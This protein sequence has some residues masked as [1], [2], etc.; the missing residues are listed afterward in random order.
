MQSPRSATPAHP[1]RAPRQRTRSRRQPQTP[2]CPAEAALAKARAQSWSGQHAPA[3]A[4][5]TQALEEQPAPAL[6]MDLLDLRAEAFIASGRFPDAAADADT[7]VALAKAQK[8]PVLGIQALN[9]RAVVLMR[10]GDARTAVQ[11]ATRAVALAT[12]RQVPQLLPHALL[13]LA[14]ALLRVDRLEPS[15]ARARRA[16][17][18]FEASRDF[19]QLG[20][21]HWVIAFAH[22]NMS[23]DAQSQVAAQRALAL[24][25]QTGDAMGAGNALNVL[26]FSSQDIAERMTLLS[27]TD[28]AFESA[29]YEPG[30]AMVK[31]NLAIACAELGLYRRAGRLGDEV[32]TLITN[33]GGQ[34][35]RALQLSGLLAWKLQMGDVDSVHA[36]WQEYEDMIKSQDSATLGVMWVRLASTLAL[37]DGDSAKSVRLLRTWLR[38]DAA[39]LSGFELQVLVPLVDALLV[40]GNLRAALHTSR[41]AAKL[42]EAQNFARAQYGQS[43]DIWWAHTRA[44]LA[45]GLDEQA[46]DALQRAYGLLLDAVRNLHDE[47]L[48]RS[49]LNKVEVNRAIVR[50]WLRESTLR[51]LPRAQRFAHLYIESN[52]GEPFQRLVD[53]GTRMNE[54]RSSDEL[55][56]FLIDEVTELSG[57]ERVLLVIEDDGAFEIGGALLPAGENAPAL[58][59]AIDP[60]LLEA[61]TT[62]AVRLRHGPEGV[63]RIKQRSCLVAPLVAQTKLLGYLYVDIDGAF[64]RFHEADSDLVAMLASQGAVALANAR[65]ARALERKVALR[66]SELSEALERQT[67]TAEVLKVLGSSLTDTQPVFDAIV[68]H[69]GHLLHGS[70][71]VLWLVEPEGLRARASN[72][73]MPSK[74]VPLDHSSPIGACVVEQ[75]VIHIPDLVAA[76]PQH[77]LLSELGAGS[78]FRSGLYTPLISDG[79]AI[80]GL[81]VLQKEAQAFDEKDQRLLGAFVDQAVIAIQNANMFR[82]TKEALERQTAM[83]EVLQ[84]IASSMEDPQP[85]FDKILESCQC[86]FGADQVGISLAG[87]DGMV[88]L[89]A[90]RGS[91]RE[92]LERIYPRPMQ[93]SPVAMAQKVH[94]VVHIP[95]V[96]ANDAL[97]PF[98]HQ[99][100]RHTGNYG[101]MLAPLLWEDH[102]IGSIHVSRQPPGPFPDRDLSLLR[103][104]GDQAVIAIQN[105]KLFNEAQEARA[106]A[107][108]ANEAKSAFLATMSHEIRTP[109]NAVIG[110]S[111]LL[112]DTA[113]DHDQREFATTIRDS[114]D[115]LLAIIN[116][117][118]DF[119]KIEAGRM[120][121]ELRPFD[122]RECVE[123][124]LELVSPRATE[125]R[126]DVA[127]LFEGDVP[128]VI[129]GDVTRLRQILLN[130]LSNAVKFTEAGE[131]VVTVHADPGADGT[132]TLRFAVRDTGIGLSKK[133]M[134]RLFQSFTQADSSTTRKYG[135]TGLGLA[136]SKRLAELMGGTMQAESR[137]LGLGATFSFSLQATVAESVGTR[138]DYAGQQPELAGRRMLVV[139]DNATNRK[140]ISL[141]A[142]KW[143]MAP[144]DTESAAQA[145][146]WLE[147]GERFDVAVLD[148]HMPEMDGL[149]LAERMHALRPGLPLVLFSSL[150]R[151][152]SG[153]DKA[154][155]AAYLA[156]PLRQSQLFD[157]LSGLFAQV[158]DAPQP[159]PVATR[160]RIDPGMA[161]RHP[162]RILLAEDNVVNQKLAMRLLQQMGYRA[163][164]A[165]NGAEAVDAVGRQVYDVVLM[166]VQM[167]EMDGLEATR[168]IVGQWQA[169]QRP[170]IIAMTANAM[171]GDRE[172]CLDAGMDDYIAKPIRVDALVDALNQAKARA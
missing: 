48:R 80:G 148:M 101:M 17:Q 6:R 111:G 95:D 145:L 92:V 60:W 11:V 115:A 136:I 2:S 30:R 63:G 138:R 134:E 147:R 98:L 159:A 87:D 157:T 105:A 46:W 36:A 155:F 16:A 96:M 113:L 156:K 82:H 85:V 43:Q 126:L 32:N 71:V 99:I 66:T 133:G 160:P 112:L 1:A 67:A 122:L 68:T 20:R 45:N 89:V 104:F 52:L 137:G 84:V 73:S 161:A 21:A 40:Q 135:G 77:P 59:Q 119:S 118:L 139:D 150:G 55:Q 153:D 75:R 29:A 24:A 86:L 25:R 27:Q 165:N 49:Y 125:K 57:A 4:M 166:D 23:Q 90:H 131:V 10:Q 15:L 171:Q 74:P 88:H 123:S 172:A 44:L 56:E 110:M 103:S 108:S 47:G 120:D 163:D 144:R 121:I 53:T 128:P 164:L 117:I 91:G 31:A 167:P 151:K 93:Q 12:R 28:Q 33:M 50:A 107:E 143:G 51:K 141:Q 64:G 22:S 81:A 62:R 114:G 146:R 170:R 61:R 142:A 132:V 8:D 109:M 14:E 7:M 41:R 127:Y 54:L 158:D 149:A 65:W 169:G 106:A 13:R 97:P 35:S 38:G 140:V 3:I 70:R 124:A 129:N 79:Q 152:E 130:L 34:G 5:C 83:S 72:G 39:K 100:A 154:R 18:L 19:V 37:A 78:G 9:R 116:D 76:I 42:H 58:L 26:S 162:L 69:G 94:G 102:V 168:R